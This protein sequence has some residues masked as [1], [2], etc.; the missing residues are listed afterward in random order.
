MFTGKGPKSEMVKDTIAR[1]YT[2]L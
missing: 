1:T 2:I